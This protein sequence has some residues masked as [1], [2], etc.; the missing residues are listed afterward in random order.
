LAY[1]L[2]TATSPQIVEHRLR[3]LEISRTMPA[4]WKDEVE[5]WLG[6]WR[7]S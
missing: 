4:G 3:R 1:A 5:Q 2:A 6:P 7:N